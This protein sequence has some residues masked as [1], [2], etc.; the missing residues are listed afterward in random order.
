MS[1]QTIAPVRVGDVI[2]TRWKG[3]SSRVTEWVTHG[4]AAHQE[5]ISVAGDCPMVIAASAGM[6]KMVTWEWEARKAYF[7][8]ERI[9]WCRFTPAIP[10]TPEQRKTLHF[11]LQEAENT[12]T[13][14]RGE[15]LL[16][17]LDSLKNWLLNTPYDSY[18]AVWFRKLGNIRKTDVICSKT[19]NIGLVR[20]EF[21]PVW[22]QFWSPSDTLNKIKSST[23]WRLAEA[24]P[25]FFG[26]KVPVA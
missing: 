5:Q 7:E 12:F 10:L 18:K 24:T 6:D 22:A 16:Q 11:F 13:Y 26:G 8:R 1:E 14:S 19:V 15:L 23:S 3:V 4:R 21:L 20:L 17:G 25:G 9:D 2:F